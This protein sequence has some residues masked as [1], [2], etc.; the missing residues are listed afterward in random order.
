MV[1]ML[2]GY[3]NVPQS[4]EIYQAKVWRCDEGP[5]VVKDITAEPRINKENFIVVFDRDA[6]MGVKSDLRRDRATRFH[7]AHQLLDGPG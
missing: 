6:R 5:R 2:V 4:V 3:P 7:A 1:R